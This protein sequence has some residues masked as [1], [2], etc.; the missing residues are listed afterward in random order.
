MFYSQFYL[1]LELE[2]QSLQGRKIFNLK[3]RYSSSQDF[4]FSLMAPV[5]INDRNTGELTD[6]LKEQGHY[7]FSEARQIFA[8]ATSIDLRQKSQKNLIGLEMCWSDELSYC[9]ESLLQICLDFQEPQ[10]KIEKSRPFLVLGAFAREVDL[11]AP[12]SEVRSQV[13]VPAMIPVK[14]LN[15]YQKKRHS[16]FALQKLIEFQNY[17]VQMESIL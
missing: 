4:H 9:L 12:M 8:R 13:Q 1:G 11:N 5:T 14:S 3:K 15:L 7:F 2:N 17:Q 10:K 16:W 6:L